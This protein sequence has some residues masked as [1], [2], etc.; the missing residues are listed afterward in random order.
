MGDEGEAHSSRGRVKG[1][2]YVVQNSLG[3]V[4]GTTGL[5]VSWCGGLHLYL[6][7]YPAN[8]HTSLVRTSKVCLWINFLL[9]DLVV[10]GTG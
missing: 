8:L 4:W 5:V 6:Q 2:M 3:D 7:S 1:V 10:Q 9:G